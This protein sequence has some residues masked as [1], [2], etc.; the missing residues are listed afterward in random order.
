MSILVN[1]PLICF[2]LEGKIGDIKKVIYLFGDRHAGVEQQTQCESH[3]SIDFVKYFVKTMKKT[4]KSK[5]YDLFF[6]IGAKELNKSMFKY[7]NKYIHEFTKYFKQTI[8]V[9]NDPND[10]K[11]IKNIGSFDEPNLLL[12][13]IDIRE[14]F[15]SPFIMPYSDYLYQ[16]ITAIINKLGHEQNMMYFVLKN[17]SLIFP[18]R[19]K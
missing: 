19:L 7:K 12:H 4:D 15:Y 18:L 5:Y 13:H 14:Y 3:K 2:R 1:G 11:K 16:I 10:D 17:P 9:I 6:E 8:N